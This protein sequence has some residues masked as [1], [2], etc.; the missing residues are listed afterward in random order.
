MIHISNSGDNQS[1]SYITTHTL[2]SVYTNQIQMHKEK[3]V[4]DNTNSKFFTLD[5]KRI[6][7]KDKKITQ[8][9]KKYCIIKQISR[10]ENITPKVD[11]ET[12]TS[13]KLSS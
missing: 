13:N 3:N 10:T 5:I 1:K 12:N 8:I 6:H 2:L 4:R 7:K 11:V 9:T